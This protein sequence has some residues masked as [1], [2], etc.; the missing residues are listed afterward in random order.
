MEGRATSLTDVFK[1]KVQKLDLK[2]IHLEN[3]NLS[4][5]GLRA[6]IIQCKK[7]KNLKELNLIN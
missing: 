1:D 3:V 7:M 2:M 4:L 5:I 6:I